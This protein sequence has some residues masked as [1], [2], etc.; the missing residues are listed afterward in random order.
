MPSE[1]SEKS[2]PAL[3]FNGAAEGTRLHNM[4]TKELLA[5]IAKG[6]IVS[7]YVQEALHRLEV[8]CLT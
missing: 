1:R 7:V 4:P 3:L 6:E 2:T 5:V 8:S